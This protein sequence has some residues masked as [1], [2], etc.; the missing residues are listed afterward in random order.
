MD[1]EE[2]LRYWSTRKELRAKVIE[3]IIKNLKTV[4]PNNEL[5]VELILY[6]WA[7]GQGLDITDA[8]IFA[9]TLITEIKAVSPGSI[10]LDTVAFIRKSVTNQKRTII[11]R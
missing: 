1:E 8:S 6:G 4:D 7:L 10:E 3:D 5:D 2:L 9:N 11:K